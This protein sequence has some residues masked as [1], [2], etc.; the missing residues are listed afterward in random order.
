M[1]PS[2]LKL[3]PDK[4]R[5]IMNAAFQVFAQHDYKQANTND[6]VAKAAISKGLLFHYFGSKRNLY[7]ELYK[8]GYS[9][10]R[11]HMQ[12]RLPKQERDFFTLIIKAQRIKTDIMMGYPHLFSFMLRAY[13]EQ[14]GEVASS[15][16]SL[17]LQSIEANVALLLQQCDRSKFKDHIS[18]EQAVNIVNWMSEGFMRTK[19]QQDDMDI[20][21]LQQQYEDYLLLLKNSFYKEL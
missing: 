3:D 7:V 8:F 14:D 1:N 17:N 19:L 12:T 9:I 2:F 15:I 16:A 13:Y 10:V 6:I 21:S 4:Q 11:E 20:P 18:L 5:M